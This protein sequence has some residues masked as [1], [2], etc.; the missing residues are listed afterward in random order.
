MKKRKKRYSKQV[1][2]ASLTSKKDV[3]PKYSPKFGEDH[4]V[5]ESL[6]GKVEYHIQIAMGEVLRSFTSVKAAMPHYKNVQV[7]NTCT[8]AR[9]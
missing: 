6:I 9:M 7:L 4:Q 1:S 3:F 2:R 8:Q 5:K